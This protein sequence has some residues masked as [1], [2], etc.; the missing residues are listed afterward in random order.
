MYILYKKMPISRH[1]QQH[2]ITGNKLLFL[3]KSKQSSIELASDKT[4]DDLHFKFGL[5]QLNRKWRINVE[6]ETLSFEKYNIETNQYDKK[7]VLE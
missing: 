3:N 5:I 6:T 7:F 2:E 1:R 4:N